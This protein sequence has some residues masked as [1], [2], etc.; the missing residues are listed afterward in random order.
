[1][2]AL[3]TYTAVVICH[4]VP[5][6]CSAYCLAYLG[7][8]V[9]DSNPIHFSVYGRARSYLRRG[10]AIGPSTIQALYAYNIYVQYIVLEVDY[11]LE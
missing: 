3:Q 2:K 7:Y 10:F 4:S 6:L 5:T 9:V 8:W 11:K 1:M